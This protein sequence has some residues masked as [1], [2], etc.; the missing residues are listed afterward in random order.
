MVTPELLAA[1]YLVHIIATTVWIGGI[2]FMALVVMPAVEGEAGCSRLLAAIQKRFTP[3]ANIGLVVLIVTG[4]VQLTANSNYAGFLNFSNTWAKAI[5]LKHVSVGGMVLAAL[6][7]NLVLQPD[8][9]RM[10][11]LLTSGKAKP[12]ETAALSRRQSHLMQINVVLSIIVLL[13]TAIARAH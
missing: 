5:L 12:E 11:M 7:M 9:N 6:Y 1:S 10:T 3:I 13:F 4:M 2:V 8:I